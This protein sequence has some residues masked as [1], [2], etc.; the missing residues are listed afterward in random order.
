MLSLDSCFLKNK[1]AFITGANRGIGKQI[2]E[3][4]VRNG[5]AS[6][7]VCARKET[8]EFKV[9]LDNIHNEYDVDIHPLYFDLSDENQIKSV[10]KK[11]VTDKIEIDILVNNAGI[12]HG[13]LLQ[14]TSIDAIRNV[15]EIN[16]FAQVLIIQYI[17][18]LMMRKKTGT[19]INLSSVAGIDAYPGYSAYGCSK[20]ALIYLTKTLAKELIPYNIRVNA[21]APGLTD[22]DMAN[23]M[24]EKAKEIMISDSSMKRLACPN[25]VA[26]VALFLASEMSSFVNG[27]VIRVDGGM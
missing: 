1:T 25:E 18:K 3:L 17:S 27:Q 23:Q 19:I 6:M 5:I 10:L 20:A 7:Y 12:A 21:I 13:G 26:S 22:T 14:M 9:F 2:V 11:L 16:F 8:D 4:F 24:E 15:F